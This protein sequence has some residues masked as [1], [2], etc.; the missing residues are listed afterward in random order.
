MP[1][2]IEYDE[3]MLFSAIRLKIQ[4]ADVKQGKVEM[5]SVKTAQG[6][7]DRPWG[8]EGGFA[9]VYKFR[10]KSG[11]LCA[12]RCFRVSMK[13]DT[14]FRYERLGPYFHMHAP[15]ITAGF[16]YHDAAIMV[17][18]QGKAQN[19]PFPVIEMDWIDGVTLVEKVDE[20]CRKRARKPLKDL[21]E[22]WLTLL[23]TMQRARIAHGDLAGVNVMVRSDGRLVLIDYDGTYIPEFAGLAP[24]L[25]GQDD[26]Q[27]PQ[28]A[29]RGFH[30]HIDAFSALVI[31]TALAALAVKPDL[32][33]KYAKFDAHRK[34][35]DFNMLFRKQD[36][37][38]TRQSPLFQ[39]LERLGDPHVRDLVRELKRICLLPI[40]DVKFPFALVDPFYQ[41]KQVLAELTDALQANDDTRI[42]ASWQPVLEQYPPA[43]IHRARVR[44]AQQRTAALR[45]FRASLASGDLQRIVDSYDAAQLDT[46]GSVSAE[47]RLL[48]SLARAFLQAFADDSDDAVDLAD[49]ISQDIKGIRIV[50]PAQ[51]QQSLAR[52]RQ[53]KHAHQI[54]SQAF[55]NR[56]VAQLAAAYPFLGYT[57][58]ALERQR[59]E[60]AAA[61]MQAYNASD[62]QAFLGAYQTLRQ[63]PEPDFFMLSMDQQQRA[64]RILKHDEV[65]SQFRQALI[66]RSPWHIVRA[67]D[68]ILDGSIQVTTIEREQLVL[69]RLLT[70]ALRTGDYNQLLAA[71]TVLQQSPHSTFFV[72]TSEERERFT[73]ASEQ[74]R[75]VLI[76]RAAL[77]SKRP[78]EIVAAYAPILDTGNVLSQEELEQL[79]LARLLVDA[80]DRDDDEVLLTLSQRLQGT[81]AQNFF[82]LTPQE[83][84]RFDLAQQRVQQLEELRRVLQATPEDAQRIIE[85]YNKLQPGS[86]SALRADEHELV[87]AALKYGAMYETIRDGLQADNNDLIR[88]VFDPALAQRFSGITSLEQQRI[89]KAMVLQTLEELLNAEAHEEALQLARSL[90]QAWGY[91]IAPSLIFKLKRATLRFIRAY[92]L[93][94]LTIQID[95]SNNTNYV[96]VSWQWPTHPLIQVGLL[97]WRPGMWPER[98][99]EQRL[100]DPNWFHIWVRRKNNVFYDRKTFPVGN[101]THIYVKSYVAILD[102]WDRD[103]KW[104]FSEGRDP[105]SYAE[106]ISSQRIRHIH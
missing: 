73:F 30:E 78:K 9:V 37:Q 77:Q 93:Y 101:E 94:H 98:I 51:Q 1:G 71:Y 80:W 84:E 81:A 90:Q 54:L 65:L 34:L 48:L 91:A 58:T 17:K 38:D 102:T 5:L 29:Q 49:K 15:D 64:I 22:Q 57:T 44:L 33:D 76:F 19:Q 6:V 50:L 88:H 35:I 41:Q 79:A 52:M 97:V 55:Q 53:R 23:N 69:A 27:H 106:A 31:Y 95:E 13:P 82:I 63:D 20:L 4:D 36:F 92:D 47:E 25:T 104:R 43:Q 100:N 70:E 39:E 74:K 75:A 11:A 89:D 10:R 87:E 24:V 83:Q 66:S 72:L 105:T 61:F 14:Q 56:D 99:S 21:A 40:N 46:S 96:T 2:R 60:G 86:S 68:V 28:M 26:F 59:I 12:L 62:D 18:E 67:Y 3:A 16:K 42:V 103:E 8:I 7:M 85:V 32:W 45:T